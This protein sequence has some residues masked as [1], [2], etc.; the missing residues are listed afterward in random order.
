MK[1]IGTFAL[2]AVFV[3]AANAD[4][5]VDNKKGPQRFGQRA[6]QGPR[7]GQGQRAGQGGF[8]PDRI[9]KALDKDQDGKLSQTETPERMK[10]R[11]A[12]M[13]A[14]SD[15]FVDGDELKKA[16]AMRARRGG[17]QPG[18]G[19]AGAGQKGNA[20]KGSP[21]ASDSPRPDFAGRAGRGMDL[22]TLFKQG[23]KNGDGNLDPQEQAA[24]IEKFK[25][26]MSRM[27]Q[28]RGGDAAKKGKATDRFAR[29]DTD[30]VKPKRPG[31]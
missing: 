3:V 31:M 22:A 16:F 21:N 2:L 11:F 14:N 30:P 18:K 20:K 6:G 8:S 28:M 1:Q 24:I 13:D 9:L 4:A 17:G 19:N 15:G 23:D 29:P 10:E 5:Q 25:Q 26:A 12:Q 27:R 7:G